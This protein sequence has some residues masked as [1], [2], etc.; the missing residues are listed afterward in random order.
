VSA[1]EYIANFFLVIIGFAV[2]E[3]LKGSA[4]LI[5][6]RKN[7]V[8]YWPAL[9]VIPVVFEILIFW[10]LHVFT[11]VVSPGERIWT[12]PDVAVICLQMVPWAFISFLIF[13]SRIP[14]GFDLKKFYLENGPIIIG[15]TTFLTILVAIDMARLGDN[16]GLIVQ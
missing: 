16:T 9:L 6:E 12:T 7:I 13:P 4:K 14:E 3:L 1:T 10:F 15:I 5:R 11:V 8:F 2:S